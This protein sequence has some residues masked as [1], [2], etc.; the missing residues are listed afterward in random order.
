M[1][2]ILYRYQKLKDAGC[3]PYPM[4]YNNENRKLKRFQKWVVMRYDELSTWEEFE[5]SFKSQYDY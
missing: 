5:A 1:E 4:V 2:E 3:L